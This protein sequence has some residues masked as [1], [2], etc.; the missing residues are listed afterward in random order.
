M[1]IGFGRTDVTPR[2]GVE[3]SGFGPF[4]LRHSIGI[5]DRLWARAMA[6]EHGGRRF[7]LVS[8]DLIG[9][10][11]AIVAEVR[12][13]VREACGLPEAAV[14]V[15]CTHTHSGPGIGS[16][17]GWGEPDL[18]Y[19]ELL[20]RRLA[21]SC[22]AA[23][24]N[25]TEAT[26]SHAEVPCEGIGLNRE[27]DIDAPPLEEVLRDDWRPAKPELTDTTCQVMGFRTASGKLAGFLS[28][29][30]CHPVVCCQ[31][32]RYVHGDYAGVATNMLERENPG[33]V[34]LFL[35]GAQG[36]V[37]SCVVHKPE[38]EALLALDVIASRYAN[39]VREGLSAAKPM[40]TESIAWA[41]KDFSFS[42][43]PLDIG[44]IKGE[45]AQQEAVLQAPGATEVDDNVRMATVYALSLRQWVEKMESGE[46]MNC[47]DELQSMRIGP[48]RL[49]ASPLEVFQAIKNEV[50]ARTASS[51]VLV[52]GITNGMSGYAPD[53]TAAARGGYAAD[54]VP[55]ILG[56][57]PYAD[58]HTELVDAL[59]EM[60]NAVN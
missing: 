37:N 50:K 51:T 17:T 5:R 57:L 16:Y 28:Y 41:S 46:A 3:L 33:S 9:V 58:I 59:V 42:R 31:V 15:H 48:V 6:V 60:S 20:P 40:Q 11:A 52:M 43:K 2:I 7:V 54:Q 44:Y 26:V 32:T 23:V 12:R 56:Q 8:C 13:L 36:D 35:Q 29:F 4:V 45:L 22:C 14:M 18:A 21:A 47:E 39:S 10:P 49:L 30:G 19:T 38:A 53:R 55:L 24:A 34:G 1:K 25:L 27:Y